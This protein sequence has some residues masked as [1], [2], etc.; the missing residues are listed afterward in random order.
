MH[1]AQ[2][3]LG[4]ITLL[5]QRWSDGDR[6]A[7]DTLMP[8]MYERLQRLAHERLRDE[9]H[10][11]SVETTALVHDAYL[12]MVDLRR[13]RFQDR[14]H[15]MAMASR[16]MRRIL[17]DRARARRAEKRGGGAAPIEL[18]DELQISDDRAEA[19]TDL[20]D[21][22][23]RLA[24]VDPRRSQILEHR[25]FAGLSL[26]ETAEVLGVSLA[27][28]KRDL[29]FARAWLAAEFKGEVRL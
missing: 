3:E 19:L 27:T 14:A 5:L 2:V 12:K 26:E 23:E 22:L 15:F 16:I 18:A 13:A 7:L 21:A 17:V 9:R 4:D 28:V 6:A 11:L 20:D 8:L 1:S 10:A 29:R 25:Y 24:A